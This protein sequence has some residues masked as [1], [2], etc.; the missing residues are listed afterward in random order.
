VVPTYTRS[1]LDAEVPDQPAGM[2]MTAITG[3]AYGAERQYGEVGR[4]GAR[5]TGRP[6]PPVHVRRIGPADE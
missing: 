5:G 4:G 3:P 2:T 1:S 6:L